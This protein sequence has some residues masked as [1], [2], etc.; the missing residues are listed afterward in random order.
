VKLKTIL[1]LIV[2]ILINT[3]AFAVLPGRPAIIHL[4][5]DYCMNAP[6]YEDEENGHG[7]LLSDSDGTCFGKADNGYSRTNSVS[8]NYLFTAVNSESNE[9]YGLCE[10]GTT[11]CDPCEDIQDKVR[12]EPDNHR[13][14]YVSTCE[15]IGGETCSQGSDRIF[16]TAAPAYYLDSRTLEFPIRLSTS[17]PTF[18]PLRY[19]FVVHERPEGGAWT[20]RVNYTSGDLAEGDHTF[21]FGTTTPYKLGIYG[22][23]SEYS[24]KLTVYDKNN[25][26]DK[27]V[28]HSGYGSDTDRKV[29]FRL[30]AFFIANP[31]EFASVL[32]ADVT[33]TSVQ[34]QVIT[35]F[36]LASVKIEYGI[37]SAESGGYPNEVEQTSATG[38]IRFQLSGLTPNQ[39]YYYRL[40]WQSENVVSPHG[41]S[42]E[43]YNSVEYNFRTAPL[44]TD[45]TKIKFAVVAD[46]HNDVSK[47][48][49]VVYY[50]THEKVF[51]S[52]LRDQDLHFVIDLGDSMAIGEV[53][54]S[55]QEVD[56]S[57]YDGV[58]AMYQLT[59]APF[60]SVAG[61]HEGISPRY[62]G[63]DMDFMYLP[64]TV[65]NDRATGAG[66]F[67]FGEAGDPLLREE[68]LAGPSRT[69]Y[70]IHPDET[71]LETAMKARALIDGVPDSGY[72]YN[73]VYHWESGNN[74]FISMDPYIAS[75][76]WAV[77]CDTENYWT[78]GQDQIDWFKDLIWTS[79]HDNI[80]I[81]T[82]TDLDGWN[83]SNEPDTHETVCYGQGGVLSYVEGG[84]TDIELINPIIEAGKVGNTYIV[85]GHDHLNS[86]ET[87]KG[88]RYITVPT[89]F[90]TWMGD[91]YHQGYT[92]VLF[93][94]RGYC[95]ELDMDTY[96]CKPDKWV[97]FRATLTKD[98]EKVMGTGTAYTW[99]ITYHLD[100]DENGDDYDQLVPYYMV[101]GFSWAWAKDPVTIEN[102]TRKSHRQV[103]KWEGWNEWDGSSNPVVDG[104]DFTI[105]LVGNSYKYEP[106]Q[107]H[108]DKGVALD[109]STWKAGDKI[110]INASAQAIGMFE[111]D[112]PDVDFYALG[113]DEKEIEGSRRSWKSGRPDR[114]A[115]DVW[116][117]VDNCP[118]ICNTQQLDGDVDGI[119]DVCDDTPY[120]GGCGQN[121]CEVSCDID[122]DG[123]LNTNDNC[124]EIPNPGQ[125]DADN[126]GIGDVC[127]DCLDVDDDGV[128]DDVDNCPAIDNP[129][130]EDT[131]DG[132]GVGDACDNCPDVCNTQQLDGDGDGVGDV[133]DDTPDCDGCGSD[134]CEL[135]C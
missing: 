125:E 5:A 88:V 131:I 117:D 120:C 116:D 69:G 54:L 29:G 133:C 13:A 73:T 107:W 130:Q 129:G 78:Y 118:D 50:N 49:P 1:F 41:D 124:P 74:L 14:G 37:A 35:P 127:D 28:V 58:L 22:V 8:S 72:A 123:I 47:F 122:T 10:D 60:Y 128:C 93:D 108:I 27:R 112:G 33:T 75:N 115:D 31:D 42:G 119:G 52:N 70:M 99:K 80:F 67:G 102:R 30:P 111:I 2:A 48:G 100:Q 105:H 92:E 110:E 36:D 34:A 11:V 39:T 101:E 65:Y 17:D 132:D 89:L 26:T 76:R 53:P 32:L 85:K 68:L 113:W 7:N 16:P 79:Q 63:P 82:H 91:F 21:K 38:I 103:K 83:R 121:A 18:K 114:D 9:S 55:K 97:K 66:E 44:P 24:W 61:N 62:A 64:F 51:F 40:R 59:G 56:K 20:E 23:V 12:C 106:R 19:N 96:E 3:N 135:E 25:P 43:I 134:P 46:L 126:D 84:N 109:P 4:D 71:A 90:R 57:F 98:P 87:Y 94:P 77:D 45:D 6:Q 15:G 104:D 81:F 95:S 86:I